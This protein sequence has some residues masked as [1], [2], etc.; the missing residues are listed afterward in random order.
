[1]YSVHAT[2][3]SPACCLANLLFAIHSAKFCNCTP[4]NSFHS[5]QWWQL[6]QI[7]RCGH[8]SMMVIAELTQVC[9]LEV[10]IYTQITYI[11]VCGNIFLSCN[12]GYFTV[13]GLLGVSS[14]LFSP[15]RQTLQSHT[16]AAGDS[17]TECRTDRDTKGQ[18]Q[19]HRQN[20]GQILVSV[21]MQREKQSYGKKGR[22]IM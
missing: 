18:T 12:A 4:A 22:C 19:A 14:K 15:E 1:M 20:I 7:T 10:V 3:L 6:L 21:D 2:R 13:K 8:R 9:S 16:T 17:W 11:C 5:R